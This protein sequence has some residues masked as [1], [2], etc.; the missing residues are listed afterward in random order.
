MVTKNGIYKILN[1]VSMK[2]Y[3]GSARCSSERWS[4]YLS[5]LQS[6]IKGECIDERIR[7][8]GN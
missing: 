2:P 6:Y 3:L 1:K 8:R 4:K 7:S 5:Q